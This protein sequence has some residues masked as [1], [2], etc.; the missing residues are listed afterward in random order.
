VLPEALARQVE[1]IINQLRSVISIGGSTLDSLWNTLFWVCVGLAGTLALHAAARALIIWRKKKMNQ[2]FEW[3]R[4]ELWLMWCVL[5]ILAAQ[6]AREWG[7]RARGGTSVSCLSLP[8]P[9][10]SP[11]A[12]H[13]LARPLFLENKLLTVTTNP[14]RVHRG[15]WRRRGGCRRHFRHPA[16]LGPAGAFF[17]PGHQAPH[18]GGELGGG[19]RCLCWASFVGLKLLCC[20]AWGALG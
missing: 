11:V 5:P 9:L 20:A 4:P 7:F 14:C 15:G 12:A 1:G 2:F 10:N 6:G 3:P 19:W 8:P 17:L 16:A 18:H 13:L